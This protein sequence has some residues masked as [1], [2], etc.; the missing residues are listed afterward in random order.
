[1]WSHL[2]IAEMTYRWHW[3]GAG[4]ISAAV[5]R[6]INEDCQDC[7]FMGIRAGIAHGFHVDFAQSP[8]KFDPQIFRRL[9]RKETS[10]RAGLTYIERPDRTL[11]L[12]VIDDP[13]WYEDRRK[14]V[15]KGI[16]FRRSVGRVMEVIE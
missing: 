10:V 1:M 3:I 14:G 8:D 5:I 15:R 9:A 7:W 16:E 6:A 13:V 12:W 11:R 2:P 4:P